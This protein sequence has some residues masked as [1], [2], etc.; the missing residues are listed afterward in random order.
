MGR[1]NAVSDALNSLIEVNVGIGEAD[2]IEGTLQF[3]SFAEHR[4]TQIGSRKL[5]G[6]WDCH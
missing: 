2:R 6:E 1:T 3:S 5:L 4:G